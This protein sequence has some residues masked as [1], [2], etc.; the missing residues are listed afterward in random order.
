MMKMKNQTMFP[1]VESRLAFKEKLKQEVLEVYVQHQRSRFDWRWLLAPSV[2]FASLFLVIVIHGNLPLIITPMTTGQDQ[3]VSHFQQ[4]E[5]SNE[6]ELSAQNDM[7]ERQEKSVD[8]GIQNFSEVEKELHTI[9]SEIN[10][11]S[12]L[13]SAIAFSNL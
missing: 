8:D 5:N 1:P 13:E 6:N 4:A 12:D 11:D 7:V 10:N 9:S 2:A 3:S